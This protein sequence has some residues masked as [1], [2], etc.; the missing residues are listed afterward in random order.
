MS[1]DPREKE[2]SGLEN[3]TKLSQQEE[4]ELPG[5]CGRRTG[6]TTNEAL[7]VMARSAKPGEDGDDPRGEAW[8]KRKRNI[9]PLRKRS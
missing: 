9:E 2:I 3:I 5:N 6:F 1:G 7:G 8:T 4:N